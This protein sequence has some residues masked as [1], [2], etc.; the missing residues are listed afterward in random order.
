[1]LCEMSEI[2]Q[3]CRSVETVLEDYPRE[4]QLGSHL[5]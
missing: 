3:G 4:S 5:K 2:F 1:M